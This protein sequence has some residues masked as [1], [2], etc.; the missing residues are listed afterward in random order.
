MRVLITR[1]RRD[2]ETFAA[3]VRALGHTTFIE[4]LIDIVFADG[5]PLDLQGIQALLL[6][7]ANG[8]RAVARR[9]KE[10]AIR[11]VAVGP[12]T[13]AEAA[14]QGFTTVSESTGE[15]VDALAQ[16]IRQNLSPENGAL[17][18]ATGTVT[19]GDLKAALAGFNVRTAQFYDARAVDRLSPELIAE[20]E[21]GQIGA[22]TF[23]SPRTAAL[24][25]QFLAGRESLCAKVAALTLSPAVAAALADIPFAK[26]MVAAHPNA[27]AM[28][29]LLKSA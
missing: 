27:A 7:S 22:A 21:A 24:F 20:L 14:A 9:T 16:T 6:T 28:L 29:D 10:R 8:A 13:A 5:P 12:A 25:A 4:P 15:G 19:A 23:F 18:H 17:I 2:A 26:V 1:P 11:V 3:D